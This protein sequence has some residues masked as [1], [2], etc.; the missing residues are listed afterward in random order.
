MPDKFVKDKT[1][2]EVNLSGK[3]EEIGFN[4]LLEKQKM[5]KTIFNKI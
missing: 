2:V 3:D 5:L 1:K 4:Q